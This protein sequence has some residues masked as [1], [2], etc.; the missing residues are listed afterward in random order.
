M[1]T[2]RVVLHYFPVL[3]RA[4]ALRHAL[5]D[6]R[7]GYED[8]QV[9]PQDWPRLRTERA[10]G[11]PFRALPTLIWGDDRVAET[12]AIASFVAQRSGQ[13]DGLDRA[14]IA[15]IEAICSCCFMDILMRLA[16]VLRAD[17]YFPGCDPAR[18]LALHAP[19]VLQKLEL[20]E[21][22]LGAAEWFGGR[23]PVNADFFAAE[24]IEVVAYVLGPARRPALD[25]RL[26]RLTTLARSVSARPALAAAHESRPRA[27]TPRRDEAAVVERLR[28]V[29]LSALQL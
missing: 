24:A 9:A 7:I 19:R 2:E 21:V 26:P 29:D 10:L 8:V 20:L 27:M 22:E 4:Q 17:E 3:G 16:E 5:A 13:Y 18:A 28:A 23:E 15:R 1:T 6:R 12:L 14:A 25:A 11:G